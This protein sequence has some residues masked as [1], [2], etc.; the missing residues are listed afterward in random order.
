[1]LAPSFIPTEKDALFLDKLTRKV[2]KKLSFAEVIRKDVCKEITLYENPSYI[3]LSAPLSI[4]HIENKHSHAT[5]EEKMEGVFAYV[6]NSQEKMIFSSH[7]GLYHFPSHQF[8]FDQVDLSLLQNKEI[9]LLHA[10]IEKMDI[11]WKEKR[12]LFQLH[13]IDSHFD[14]LL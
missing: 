3:Y 7:T 8:S 12:P 4:M 2:K 6:D 10:A 1:M 9:P 5:V 13:N 14:S 11:I